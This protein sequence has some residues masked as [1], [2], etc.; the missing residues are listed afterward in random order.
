[1][2]TLSVVSDSGR[3]KRIKLLESNLVLGLNPLEQRIFLTE[4][5]SKPN[6]KWFLSQDE[7]EILRDYARSN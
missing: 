2:A 1:M 3:G 7:F 5:A 4:L 6:L